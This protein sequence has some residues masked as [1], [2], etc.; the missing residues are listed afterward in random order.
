[1]TLDAGRLVKI[2]RAEQRDNRFGSGYL[3]TPDLVLTAAHVCGN[4]KISDSCE[5]RFLDPDG[6]QPWL[7]AE[8]VWRSD[9]HESRCLSCT[10]HDGTRLAA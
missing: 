2:Y 8:I 5:V 1:M 9:E 10:T 3:V 6:T 4:G 7:N